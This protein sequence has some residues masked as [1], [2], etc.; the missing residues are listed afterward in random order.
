MI[1]IAAHITKAAVMMTTTQIARLRM[2]GKAVTREVGA[3]AFIMPTWPRRSRCGFDDNGK[4]PAVIR[5][6]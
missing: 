6:G 4:P 5:H 1:K 3:I 2:Y